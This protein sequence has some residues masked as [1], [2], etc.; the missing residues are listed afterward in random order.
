MSER[1]ERYRARKA[2]SE[3]GW[4][5]SW[6][7][8]AVA[9]GGAFVAVRGALDLPASRAYLAGGLGIALVGVGLARCRPWA[10]WPGAALLLAAA[11]LQLVPL[12][13]DGFDLGS[14]LRPAG[15]AAAAVFLALI[16]TGQLLRTAS[17]SRRGVGEDPRKGSSRSSR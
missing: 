4:S 6:E 16:E 11:V 3:L 8:W 14:M 7:W 12:A 17:R 5:W 13:R 9:A 2:R 1:L 10:R 15:F